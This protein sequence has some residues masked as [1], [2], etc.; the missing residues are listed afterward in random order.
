MVS[1]PR[2]GGRLVPVHADSGDTTE[3]HASNGFYTGSNHASGNQKIE[4]A[5]DYDVYKAGQLK[6]IDV[7]D[8]IESAT[9]TSDLAHEFGHAAYRT[10][11]NGSF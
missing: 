10:K 6:H 11:L 7:G 1:I 2:L 8:G 3:F 4:Y 9:F 5:S